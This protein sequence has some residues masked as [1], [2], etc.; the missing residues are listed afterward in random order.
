MRIL[1]AVVDGGG[2]VPPQLAVAR[3]LRQR[4]AEVLVVGHSGIRGRVESA[5]LNFE[6]FSGGRHF[7]PT[8]QRSMAALMLDFTLVAADRNVGRSVVEAA[9]RFH[10]DA[11]VVDMILAAAI[12]EIDRCGIPT[13]VFVH[14]FYQAVRDMAAG[15]VGWLLRARGVDPLYAQHRGLLQ[16]VSA[17]ADLD[18][19]PTVPQVSHTGVAWQG[20]PRAASQAPIPRVLVSLSTN[21]FAG[22]P[23]MLQN[24]L[25]ALAPQP[26]DVTVTVGPSIDTS[27]TRVPDNA[28]LHG[29]LDHDEVLAEASLVVGHGGHSTAMRALSFSVPQVILPANPLIDQKLVG[30]VL[31]SRGA[32]LALPKH[33]SPHRIRR[34]T[35]AVLQGD[36]FRRAAAEFG[37]E[38]RRSDGAQVAADTI[39]EFVDRSYLRA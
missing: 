23:K 37:E 20:V 28:T 22:Q 9:H 4:G 5:G 14:C 11:V 2:N 6:S 17:R 31:Q 30:A 1:F 29:W 27:R 38:I 33:A 21:A 39:S 34:A 18:P 12:P 35:E 32:G 24:I 8:V 36:S 15:P 3:A 26:V 13:V 7:D 16:I 19:A 10:A 25:D